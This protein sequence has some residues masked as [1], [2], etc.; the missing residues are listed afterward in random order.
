M[1]VMETFRIIAL[2]YVKGTL[3]YSFLKLFVKKPAY[4]LTGPRMLHWIILGVH[5]KGKIQKHLHQHLQRLGVV[6]S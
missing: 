1:S 3:F 6:S 5:L 4:L 2:N